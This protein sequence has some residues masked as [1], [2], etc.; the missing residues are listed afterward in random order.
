MH[1]PRPYLFSALQL[2]I[3]IGIPCAPQVLRGASYFQHALFIAKA[4]EQPQ[5]CL[6]ILMDDMV[7]YDEAVEFLQQLP[8]KQA[9]QAVQRHGKV[10]W[11]QEITAHMGWQER[12]VHSH[13]TQQRPCTHELAHCLSLMV[14][15]TASR[16]CP[17]L[18][19]SPPPPPTQVLITQRPE[20]TTA[21]LMQLCT[22]DGSDDWAAPVSDMA[23]LFADRPQ[24]LLLLCEFILNSSAAPANERALYHM[25]LYLYLD[26][27][28]WGL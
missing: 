25:L 20:P 19:S 15:T 17:F 21:L 12:R 23:H 11:E 9:A 14:V 1:A 10:C 13:H 3:D 24:A 16:H 26:M 22:T 27:C 28:V 6:D 8:R 18:T 4:S 5:V 7:Q 2:P